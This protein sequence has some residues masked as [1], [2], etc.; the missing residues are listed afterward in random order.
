MASQVSLQCHCQDVQWHLYDCL[1]P[2]I[3][4]S[5]VPFI[6]AV[7]S[8]TWLACLTKLCYF[9]DWE[10]S[11]KVKDA[12]VIDNLF[13]VVYSERALMSADDYY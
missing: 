3:A 13:T 1:Q 7:R 12:N 10:L 4:E 5:R 8:K 2:L 6:S 9:V 11:Q